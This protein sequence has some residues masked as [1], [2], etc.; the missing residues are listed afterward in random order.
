MSERI[1][2]IVEYDGTDFCGWQRQPELVSIQERI[3]SALEKLFQSRVRVT[4]AGR[5][6]AGAHALGQ[7]ISF[8]NPSS[9]PLSNILK[10]SNT[11]LPEAIRI[12]DIEKVPISF[13]PRRDAILRWYRYCVINRSPAPV[14]ARH[15]MTHIPYKIDLELL[16]EAI[17]LFEGTKNFSA[18]RSIDCEA[19]RT[20]LTLKKFQFINRKPLL[21]FDLECRS[22]LQNMVRILVGAV[23]EAARGKIPLSLLREMLETGRRN[24]RIPTLPASGL[25]LMRVYYP[26]DIPGDDTAEMQFVYPISK[27]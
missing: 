19:E 2:A 20:L 11:Y 6:D 27:S 26:G 21:V 10:G 18:F 15:F 16:T 1:K 12:V 4:A 22:F 25:T 24:N 14:W 5:T 17:G 8:V 3:E 9:I 7:V 23:T 13:N